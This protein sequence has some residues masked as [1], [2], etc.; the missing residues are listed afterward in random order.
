MT[1][2]EYIITQCQKYSNSLWDESIHKDCIEKIKTMS[3]EDRCDLLFE[4]VIHV[5][6]TDSTY[7]FK[8]EDEI[9]EYIDRHNELLSSIV[10]TIPT[11]NLVDIIY[12]SPNDYIGKKGRECSLD[13][14]NAF[15]CAYRCARDELRN[16]YTKDLDREKIEIAF[17]NTNGTNRNW[18]KW[19]IRKREIAEIRYHDPFLEKLKDKEI[20]VDEEF[21]DHATHGFENVISI[22]DCRNFWD[23]EGKRICAIDFILKTCGVVPQYIGLGDEVVFAVASDDYELEYAFEY[24]QEYR[25]SHLRDKIDRIFNKEY[26]KNIVLGCMLVEKYIH[27][28]D[29]TINAKVRCYDQNYLLGHFV[30]E[31]PDELFT[32]ID[33]V[34][35]LMD[36]MPK[37]GENHNSFFDIVGNLM[38]PS[39]NNEKAL[40][41]FSDLAEDT[42]EQQDVLP[43]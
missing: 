43:F 4:K 6:W 16:R 41:S 14:L 10:K 39:W 22:K 3:D 32:T 40:N 29:P 11:S 9:T 20:F 36:L 15:G 2:Y 25:D 7:P 33:S 27:I 38:E 24:K 18:L 19:Q 37:A 26:D 5:K 21:V 1:D 12:S 17:Y 8:N 30:I 13:F 31:C 34:A 23:E 28:A 42:S 35:K